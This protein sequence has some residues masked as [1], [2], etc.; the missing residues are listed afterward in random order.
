MVSE[1]LPTFAGVNVLE[2]IAMSVGL[3]NAVSLA[4]CHLTILPV[5]GVA[6]KLLES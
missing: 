6:V 4:F 1:R 3:V 5:V 2:V